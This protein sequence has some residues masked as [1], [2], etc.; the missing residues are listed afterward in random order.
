M[1]DAGAGGDSARKVA[2][3]KMI[4]LQNRAACFHKLGRFAEAVELCTAGSSAGALRSKSCASAKP[5]NTSRM[6]MRVCVGEA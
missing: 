5:A 2:V 1:A 6:P 4:L 3:M